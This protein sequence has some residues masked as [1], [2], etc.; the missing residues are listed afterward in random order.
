MSTLYLQTAVNGNSASDVVLGHWLHVR[1][2]E[3]V[4]RAGLRL[5]ESMQLLGATKRLDVFK[6]LC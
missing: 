5:L 6:I 2:C 4:V 3:G 1:H